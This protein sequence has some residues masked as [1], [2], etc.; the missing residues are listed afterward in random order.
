M[1]ELLRQGLNIEELIGDLNTLV[2]GI[3]EQDDY[4][5]KLQK[6]QQQKSKQ[7]ED[8]TS[9]KQEEGDKTQQKENLTDKQ[10]QFVSKSKEE[11]AA[12]IDALD[13]WPAVA[14]WLGQYDLISNSDILVRYHNKKG[15]DTV[16]EYNDSLVPEIVQDFNGNPSE[17]KDRIKEVSLELHDEFSNEEESSSKESNKQKGG[18]EEVS[19]NDIEQ[20]FDEDETSSEEELPSAQSDE[21]DETPI[22]EDLDKQDED[23]PNTEVSSYNDET[24]I[25]PPIT[26]EQTP[27]EAVTPMTTGTQ[28]I[29]TNQGNSN[30]ENSHFPQTPLGQEDALSVGRRETLYDINDLKKGKAT[31]RS[32]EFRFDQNQG[33]WTTKGRE[34]VENGDLNRLQEYWAKTHNG[35]KL[36]IRLVRIHHGGDFNVYDDATKN[37]KVRKAFYRD[38]LF[39]AVEIPNGFK[40]TDPP[41]LKEYKDSE[42]K[43]HAEYYTTVTDEA[44]GGKRTSMLI[45]GMITAN[46]DNPQLQE[47]LKILN[48]SKVEGQK[49]KPQ[50][51]VV[52]LAYDN[53]LEILQKSHP[54][55]EIKRLDYFSPKITLNLEW[56][57]SGRIIKSNERNPKV[58]ERDFVTEGFN[59]CVLTEKEYKQ[60]S[61]KYT[62]FEIAVIAASEITFG[63]LEVTEDTVT[64]APNTFR[65]QFYNSLQYSKANNQG[66]IWIKTKES[67]GRIYYKGVKLKAFDSSYAVDFDQATQ[68]NSPIAARLKQAIVNMVK[69]NKENGGTLDEWKQQLAEIQRY[70]YVPKTQGKRMFISKEGFS[71][72]KSGKKIAFDSPDAAKDIYELIRSTGY[73][74]T[75][76]LDQK[77]TLK[78]IIDSNILTTD[79][80]QIHNAGASFL[81]SSVTKGVND[82]I[83]IV[84]SQMAK[85]LREGEIQHTGISRFDPTRGQMSYITVTVPEMANNKYYVTLDEKENRVWFLQEGERHE[86]GRDTQITDASQ[87]AILD[88]ALFVHNVIY[89]AQRNS[90]NRVGVLW[91]I[92]NQRNLYPYKGIK[93][94]IIKGRKMGT[95][96]NIY[97][98]FMLGGNVAYMDLNFK[99]YSPSTDP[100][101]Q[102]VY[103]QIQNLTTNSKAALELLSATEGKKVTPYNKGVTVDENSYE[104]DE[105]NEN[106]HRI[107]F[108]RE[109]KKGELQPAYIDVTPEDLNIDEEYIRSV[110]GDDVPDEEVKETLKQFIAAPRIRIMSITYDRSSNL[111]TAAIK[112]Y[113]EDGKTLYEVDGDTF[114]GYNGLNATFKD[115]DEISINLNS[116]SPVGLKDLISK[117]SIPFKMDWTPGE[118]T[119]EKQ[120]SEEKT[121][122]KEEKAKTE[123][124]TEK[125]SKSLQ[126]AFGNTSQ[127]TSA[128]ESPT[129]QPEAEQP[130]KET[131]EEEGEKPP[132]INS[133]VDEDPFLSGN[134]SGF[135]EINP[136]S[137]LDVPD[138]LV[139]TVADITETDTDEV[140]VKMMEDSKKALVSEAVELYNSGQQQEAI[141]K[142][143]DNLFC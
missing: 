86:H 66:T 112:L 126:E 24:R 139:N 107:G 21:A 18:E 37:A 142:L 70:I 102:S 93:Y 88:Q 82:S 26:S 136:S 119:K 74:F 105:T 33:I 56:I 7:Q 104:V 57:F 68:E 87:I 52:N 122:K 117:G 47:A 133:P 101:I 5:E 42:G 39:A 143:K 63:N 138:E 1:L 17:T 96:S 49:G 115:D 25:L 62:P 51:G 4:N 129:E 109:N 134:F 61:E 90:V 91:N 130:K 2:K 46:K 113:Q 131:S 128:E 34:F 43:E 12:E 3:Q 8:K 116:N 121:E 141:Q 50:K 84:P 80:A 118:I 99:V 40:L 6:Q 29:N 111:I 10:K 31:S 32:S 59:D 22:Q 9:K 110:L 100:N 81:V 14:G 123:I 85:Q 13:T 106:I 28:I 41:G 65:Y 79:L 44:K 69:T 94:S 75:L 30:A 58:K 92:I 127:E 48:D 135:E 83:N 95:D 27:K 53:Q 54:D 38:A 15:G 72:T 120:V 125:P 73:T 77:L 67:D 16:T 64:V 35:Q 137:T 60:L 98:P 103:T 124:P 45:L 36:P 11:I 76:G 140:T 71:I 55:A 114:L 23:L 78:E 19:S 89:D 97:F 108:K 132:Q 20:S